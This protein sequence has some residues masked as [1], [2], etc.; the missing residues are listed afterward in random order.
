MAQIIAPASNDGKDN[1]PSPSKVVQGIRYYRRGQSLIYFFR[2]YH[3]TANDRGETDAEM[4]IEILKDEK[5]IIQVPWQPAPSRQLGKD[6]K[7]L[8]IGGQL[9]LQQMQPGIYELR[10]SVKS[11]KM[12]RPV[13]R[14]VAFGIEP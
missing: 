12:K 4:Q 6:A 3:A 2:L 7:G 1:S 10:V 13:Q 8:V 5:A 14:S 11:Q 9:A